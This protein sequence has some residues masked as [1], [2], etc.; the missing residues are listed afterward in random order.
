MIYHNHPDYD[1]AIAAGVRLAQSNP[2]ARVWYDPTT[3]NIG[4]CS[5]D[6][7]NF[8]NSDLETIAYCQRW[9]FRT[10][11]VRLQSGSEYVPCKNS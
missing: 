6:H 11:E 4:A 7:A 1:H 10:I 5:I 3:D 9:D 2:V 8:D